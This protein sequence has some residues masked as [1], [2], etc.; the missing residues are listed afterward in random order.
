MTNHPFVATLRNLR[1]NVRGCV[2]TEALWAIPY[3]L[4]AP[5]VSVYML[6][7]GLTDSMIG[8]ITSVGMVFQIFW[9]LISG[10][11]TD[12]LGRKRTTLIF[13]II[14]WSVPC[15]IWAVA[16]DVTYFFVAAIVNAV[17][18]VT[19][20]SWQCLLVEDTDRSLLVDVY[21]WIYIAGLITAFVSPVT[22]V[23]I[24]RFSLVPTMRALYF[25]SFIMMTAK[26]LIMNAMV[27]E[28]KQGE[29]RMHETRH[30]PLFAV[31]SG[32]T[33]VLKQIIR[34]PA[35]L[36]TAGLMVLLNICWLI[37]GT[38]WS[39]LVTEKLQIPA[40]HLVIFLFARSII[41]LLFYFAVMPRLR[42]MDVRK[43]MLWGLLGLI[44]SQV[45]L[46]SV[47]P[48][49]YVMLIVATV[50]EAVSTPTATTLLDKLAVVSVDPRERARIM[51]ILYVA[52]IV[53]TSPFGWIAGVLSQANRSLP[54]VL[55]IVLF[56]I[57]GVL[58][59][60]A[61]RYIKSEETA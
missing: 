36:M 59:L 23:L 61:S 2:Y 57:G 1:G 40:E 54:F 5:Y 41:M 53:L 39:I 37:K 14:S 42:Y 43:P 4:Y 8:L 55:N 35:T 46:V 15:L 22:G 11:I 50:L 25:F 20:N 17:W 52:V 30:Q 7:F 18:R 47:A 16:Q 6:A 21:S 60:A 34:T 10:A 38:F 32:S 56:A 45:I 33:G 48:R 9:T 12:K 26:F 19:S 49:D 58:V 31:L 44:V 51:A 13:D 28:T 29:V 27:T 3:N 24:D